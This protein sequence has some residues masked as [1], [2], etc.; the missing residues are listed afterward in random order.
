MKNTY[1]ATRFLL[2]AF[3]ALAAWW[4]WFHRRADIHLAATT[5]ES[6]PRTVL[7]E[8]PIYRQA[9]TRWAD[10]RVGGSG[11]PLRLVGCTVCCLSMA[12]DQHGIILSPAELNRRLQQNDGYT[13]RGWVKWERLKQITGDTIRIRIPKNP[14]P[15]DIQAALTTGN[16]VL[17]KVSLGSAGMHWVLIVG[18]DQREYL[19]KDPLS[20]GLQLTTLSHFGSEILDVR[21]VEKAN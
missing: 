9:D 1:R 13:A 15:H 3:C 12:L 16:P 19:V 6:V 11:E 8:T 20:D 14:T 18:R 4:F 7:K 10:E 21:I 2:I 17:V 5:T